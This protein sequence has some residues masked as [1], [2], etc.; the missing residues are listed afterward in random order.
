MTHQG[1]TVR[2]GFLLRNWNT[3]K[4]RKQD[5]SQERQQSQA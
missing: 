5:S 4:N 2:G 3:G 1:V